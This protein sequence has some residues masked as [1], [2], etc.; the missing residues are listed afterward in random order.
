MNLP[1]TQE[2]K[3]LIVRRDNIGDLICTTPLISALRRRYPRA[4]LAAL[5]NT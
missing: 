5:A 3:I 2:P 1:A 4:H